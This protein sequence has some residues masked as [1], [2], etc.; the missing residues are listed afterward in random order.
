MRIGI[1]ALYLIPGGVGGTEVYLRRLVEALE[2]LESG[3]EFVI[4][5]NRETGRL[6]KRCVELP[7]RAAFRP[8]RLL[9][10]QLRLPGVLKREGIDALLNPGFT[11]P[12][13]AGVPQVTVFHDLQHK[14]HPEFFRW[15]DLP[16]WELLL[17]VAV[18]RS[19]RLIAVSDATRAD[20]K[21]YYGTD[22]AVVEHGVEPEFFELARRREDGGVFAVRFHD[23]SA[24]E[25]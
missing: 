21:K 3:H 10:E 17:W 13:W 19:E 6:G 1:N 14:R 2:G 8:G 9:Y 7:V 4:L 15:F 11:A 16:F 5:T 22:A 12:A 23:A 18:R 20:L 24:Q 25:S